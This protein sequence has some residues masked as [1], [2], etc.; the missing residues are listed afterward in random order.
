M[1]LNA[2]LRR[3]V[4]KGINHQI[5]PADHNLRHAIMNRRK[6]DEV[7]VVIVTVIKMLWGGFW[8]LVNADDQKIGAVV[9]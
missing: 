3:W 4:V 8:Q 6:A 7:I 1:S 2:E 9:A 5:I